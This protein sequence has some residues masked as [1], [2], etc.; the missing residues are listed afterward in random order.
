MKRFLQS[1]Y[2]ATMFFLLFII[3]CGVAL[4]IFPD[5]EDVK[6]GSQLD[7]EIR[8]NSK[9]YPILQG[10]P[11]VKQYVMNVGNQVIASPEI[12]KRGIYAYQYEIIHDDKTINAFC[13]P[14]G[15]IYVY[16]GL[17]KFIDN[18]ATL[19]GILGHEIA[20]AERRH[21]TTRITKTY[22]IQIALAFA[23]GEKPSQIAEIGA[24]LLGGL[25]L[26]ANSRADETESDEY[27]LKYLSSTKYYPGGV[28]YFFDKIQK[29]QGRQGGGTV[30]R[31]LS[32]HP[33][34]PDRIEHVKQ[35]LQSMGNPQPTENKLLS[36][37]Y[38]DFKKKLP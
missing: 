25:A 7:K 37:E 30:E 35:L 9:E 16:T 12:K 33:L 13:T 32:T 28:T 14:G 22:G 2:L 3:G 26:L 18:E 1:H 5:S 4:N 27:S 15:Y 10:H 11:E 24:N 36:K 21:A 29:E 34:P 20:H 23:L 31:L 8:A 19:A 17:L 6:L 38:Q